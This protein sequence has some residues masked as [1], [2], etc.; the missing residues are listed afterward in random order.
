[1]QDIQLNNDS[2]TK[3][4]RRQALLITAVAMIAV[5]VLWNVDIFS[6]LVTPL[7]L[8]VT[9]VHEAGHGVMALLT[10]GKIMGFVVSANGSGLTQTMGGSRALILPA[11]YLGAAAF[12]SIL[13][14]L[15]NRF[16][17]AINNMPI[18]LGLGMVAY[19]LVY[20]RPDEASGLLA[21]T[22]GVGF[23]VLLI[24]IGARAPRLVALLTINV[25]AVSTALNAVLDLWN[26]LGH[27]GATRGEVQN[28]AAAFARD[29]T[30]LLP[31]SF[32][33]LTW[34]I[35]AVMMFG[36]AVYFGVWKR[37]RAE[38]DEGYTR[39]TQR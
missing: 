20:A 22:L 24:L 9:Y 15:A 25:L 1:M 5:Y 2:N 23:G 12:G 36:A 19:T 31:P 33:A 39:L 13:F 29:I 17:R 3:R 7:R 11:G 8:F 14:Y 18:A 4:D 37:L 30:P 35:L 26:L 34:A 38:I 21:L 10:G 32:V 28:D 27:I 16:P 6:F